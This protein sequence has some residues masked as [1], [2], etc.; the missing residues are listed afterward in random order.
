MT[1]EKEKKKKEK[2]KKDWSWRI[3][4]SGLAE[5]INVSDDGQHG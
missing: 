4:G 3:L 2:K 5:P 1:E